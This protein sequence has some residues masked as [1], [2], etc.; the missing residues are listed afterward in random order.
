MALSRFFAPQGRHVAPLGVKFGVDRD[1][2]KIRNIKAPQGRIP[3]AIFTIFAP[4]APRF[5]MQNFARS[6]V[7][8]PC[9]GDSPVSSATSFVNGIW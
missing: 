4:F 7:V 3:S 1:F 8:A 5:A 2:I 9:G 6:L